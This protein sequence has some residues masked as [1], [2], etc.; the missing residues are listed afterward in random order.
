MEP[1]SKSKEEIIVILEGKINDL[2]KELSK[3]TEFRKNI[4]EK[5][6]LTDT[7]FNKLR[8]EMIWGI[9]HNGLAGCM[10]AL[11]DEVFYYLDKK[12]R[13]QY[14]KRIWGIID[15]KAIEILNYMN[16]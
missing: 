3:E 9:R 4:L 14:E 11:N 13:M 2:E 10:D 5:S 6:D 12:E 8:K 15:G 16:F 7:D 1:A